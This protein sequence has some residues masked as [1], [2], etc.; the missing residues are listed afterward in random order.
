VIQTLQAARTPEAVVNAALV[1]IQE[2]MD[3]IGRTIRDWAAFL[4]AVRAPEQ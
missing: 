4:E 1:P 3:G 2:E